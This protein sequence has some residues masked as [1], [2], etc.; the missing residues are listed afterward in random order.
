MTKKDIALLKKTRSVKFDDKT[1]EGI[2]NTASGQD[3]SMGDY[4]RKGI[5]D[6]LNKDGGLI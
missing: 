1:W 2:R 5:R 4:I 3:V 6:K